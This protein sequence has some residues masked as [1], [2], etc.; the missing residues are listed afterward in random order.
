MILRHT[1]ADEA[2]RFTI[3][4][5]RTAKAMAISSFAVGDCRTEKRIT[6]SLRPQ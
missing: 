4:V 1:T 5:A 6:L 3:V 2:N